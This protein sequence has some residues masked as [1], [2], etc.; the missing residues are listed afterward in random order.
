M[1]QRLEF[2]KR[3]VEDEEGGTYDDD[4]G[5]EEAPETYISEEENDEELDWTKKMK[6]PRLTMVADMVENKKD[7]KARLF[8]KK[9]TKTETIKRKI[10]N[11]NKIEVFEEESEEE[12]G[13]WGQEECGLEG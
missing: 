2:D 6:K 13:G 5:E 10:A 4:L 3:V 11:R 8:D 12:R 1:K 7:V 9:E